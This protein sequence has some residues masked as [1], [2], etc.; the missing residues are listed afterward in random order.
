MVGLCLAS[1]NLKPKR[2]PPPRIRASGLSDD[3]RKIIWCVNQIAAGLADRAKRVPSHQRD[4]LIDAELQEA[5]ARICRGDRSE[6]G[7]ALRRFER[8]LWTGLRD[9]VLDRLSHSTYSKNSD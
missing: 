7:L 6:R 5:C 8:T 9:K 2:R 4:R 3:E 1:R